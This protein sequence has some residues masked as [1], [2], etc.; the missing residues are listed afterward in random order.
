MRR[1]ASAAHAPRTPARARAPRLRVHLPGRGAGPARA[2]DAPRRRCGRTRAS[3]AP[4][5]RR[6]VATAA[7]S[8]SR[9]RRTR[10]RTASARPARPGCRSLLRSRRSPPTG[11]RASTGS[12]LE[13]YR[14]ALRLRR[15]HG[16]GRGD[17]RVGR[18]RMRHSLSFANR[19]VRVLTN[20]GARPAAAAGGRAH[21]RRQRTGCGGRRA[22]APDRTVWFSNL[23][24]VL[25]RRWRAGSV[26]GGSERRLNHVSG[27]RGPAVGR[28]PGERR[29]RRRA[30]GAERRRRRRSRT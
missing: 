26:V 12:T 1:S 15:E 28:G 17:A 29:R 25:A 8:R 3:S 20:F 21:P 16:L 18:G 4:A 11:R 5:G 24:S 6:R 10:R 13:L 19:G 9:G 22:L 14:A 23:A 2:H 7:A 27:M 30:E